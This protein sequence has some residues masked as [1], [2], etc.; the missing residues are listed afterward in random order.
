METEMTLPAQNK[1]VRKLG[2]LTFGIVMVASGIAFLVHTIFDQISY[3]LIFRFWPTIFILLGLEILIGAGK[4]ETKYKYDIVSVFLMMT[5]V[6]F[7][8]GLAV[9]DMN[10]EYLHHW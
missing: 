1:N 9:I 2:T 7:A 5:L 3:E 6:F 4:R 10:W 8:M